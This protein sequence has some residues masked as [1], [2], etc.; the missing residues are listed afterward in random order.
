[1][2]FVTIRFI[3]NDKVRLRVIKPFSQ[4]RIYV[5]EINT[6]IFPKAKLLHIPTRNMYGLF[7]FFCLLKGIITLSEHCC[8]ENCLWPAVSR[9]L[10]TTPATG[11]SSTSVQSF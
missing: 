7:C 3:P 10:R 1:M 8:M 11:A 5:L 9:L 2:F 4:H 6:W